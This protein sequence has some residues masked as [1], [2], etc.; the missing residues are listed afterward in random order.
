M[1]FWI[2]ATFATP[3]ADRF[4][5]ESSHIEPV[6]MLDPSVGP[7]MVVHGRTGVAHWLSRPPGRVGRLDAVASATEGCPGPEMLRP[8]RRGWRQRGRGAARAP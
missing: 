6:V 3:P 7:F 1:K 4:P 8:S 5:S 2:P